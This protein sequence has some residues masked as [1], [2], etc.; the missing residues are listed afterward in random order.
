MQD[1]AQAI[2]EL[3][4][5]HTRAWAAFE[6]KDLDA[7][8]SIFSPDL[9]CYLVNGRTLNRGGFMRDIAALFQRFSRARWSYERGQLEFVEDRATETLTLVGT[10]GVTAFLILH[11]AWDV[12]QKSRITWTRSEGQWFV[13]EIEVLEEKVS[14]RPY[15]FALRPPFDS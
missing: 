7:Y 12:Y 11:R 2:A 9:K 14:A 10:L 6:Q 8:F 3:D 1:H 4:A 13:E 15:R 5:L